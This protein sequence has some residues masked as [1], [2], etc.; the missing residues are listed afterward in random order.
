MA[1]QSEKQNTFIWDIKKKKKK[2]QSLLDN[3]RKGER[4]KCLFYL[5]IVRPHPCALVSLTP[6]V[7]YFCGHWLLK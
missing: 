5:R 3:K 4:K 2:K 6:S 1:Q 7:I